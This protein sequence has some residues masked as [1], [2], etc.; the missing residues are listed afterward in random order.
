MGL[1]FN[2]EFAI[3]FDT[4]LHIHV[5]AISEWSDGVNKKVSFFQKLNSSTFKTSKIADPKELHH[6]L[7]F[8][9]Y[10]INFIFLYFS[11]VYLCKRTMQNKSRLE[12]DDYEAVSNLEVK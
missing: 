6:L 2:Q 11:A 10:Q 1:P 4:Y 3:I 12:L 5:Y 7:Q 8:K 9:S